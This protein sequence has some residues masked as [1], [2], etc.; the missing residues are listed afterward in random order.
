MFSVTIIIMDEHVAVKY[1][2]SEPF[3]TYAKISHKGKGVM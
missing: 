3:I 2:V 1:V